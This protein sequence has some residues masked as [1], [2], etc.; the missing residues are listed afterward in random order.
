MDDDLTATEKKQLMH[1]LK[2][3]SDCRKLYKAFQR[4]REKSKIDYAVSPYFAQRVL[5]AWKQK[6]KNRDWREMVALPAS[7][8]KAGLVAT[9]VFVL[10]LIATDY[11]RGSKTEPPPPADSWLDDMNM[12]AVLVNNDQALRFALNTYEI[13]ESSDEF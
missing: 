3:C 2:G 12:Q 5:N 13:K 10:L 1:H 7:I 4:L 6:Q 11:I 8:V 9:T